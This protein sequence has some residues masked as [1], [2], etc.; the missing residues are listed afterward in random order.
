M[1]RVLP[2]TATL[3]QGYNA[4]RS[5]IR[6]RVQGPSQLRLWWTDGTFAAEPVPPTSLYHDT[7]DESLHTADQLRRGVWLAGERRCDACHDVPGRRKAA[8]PTGPSLAGVGS[9]LDSAWIYRWLLD[10]AAI[11]PQ[12]HMPRMFA[13]DKPA[14]RQKAADIATYLSGLGEAD[15]PSEAALPKSPDVAGAALFEDLGCVACHRLTEPAEHDPYD[16]LPL[17]HAAEKF[18]P[19]KLAEFLRRPHSHYPQTRMPDFALTAAEAAALAQ[20]LAGGEQVKRPAV[21]ELAKADARRGEAL[22]REQR[23]QVC[24]AVSD[25]PA[26]QTSLVPLGDLSRGC[27]ADDPARAGAAPRFSLTARQIADLGRAAGSLRPVS[28]ANHC[29]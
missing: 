17:A 26:V 25:R 6:R 3:R 5:S 4:W 28:A 2:A 20:H 18:R 11:R 16:R 7:R 9:R 23:C 15:V 29:G 8:R 24:H 27:M 12:A 13:A 21:P 1:S 19:G 22:F 14:D 10:P